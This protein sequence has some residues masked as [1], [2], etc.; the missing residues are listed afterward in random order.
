MIEVSEDQLKQVEYLLDQ[1]QKGHHVLFR[2]EDLR[3]VFKDELDLPLQESE[4]YGAEPTIEKLIALPTLA[5]K[6][7]F[8]EGLDDE[9][10]SSVVR[11]YFAI[12]E[13]AL[14]ERV[15]ATH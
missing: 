8:L 9:T 11:T 2:S 4:A 1:S 15:E 5:Q 14:I 7:A 13:N 12:V 3:R 6:R 10:F